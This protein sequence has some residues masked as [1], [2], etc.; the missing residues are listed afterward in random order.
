MLRIVDWSP[1]SVLQLACYAL[2]SFR[3]LLS[4]EEVQHIEKGLN[5]GSF[6]DYTLGVSAFAQMYTNKISTFTNF[7]AKRDT[8]IFKV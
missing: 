4:S 8:H 5:T 1:V 3:G 7:H 6:A 2:A